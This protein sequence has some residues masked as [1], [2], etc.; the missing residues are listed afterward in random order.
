M[1]FVSRCANQTSRYIQTHEELRPSSGV[2]KTKS[3]E[4]LRPS[5]VS[6]TQTYE[7][8]RPSGVSKTQTHEKLISVFISLYAEKFSLVLFVFIYFYSYIFYLVFMTRI[9]FNFVSGR[10]MLFDTKF[11][12]G[13]HVF[14]N[15][16]T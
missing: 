5:G 16:Y 14:K 10:D 8:L 15:N 3:H 9:I 12:F 7:K 4:K 6:K 13:S 11:A 1:E 2:T